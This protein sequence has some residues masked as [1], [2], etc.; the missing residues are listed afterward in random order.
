MPYGGGGAAANPSQFPSSGGGGGGSGIGPSAAGLGL[1]LMTA[2]PGAIVNQINLNAQSL[3]VSLGTCA[4][5]GTATKLGA[6][7]VVAG[8]T[9]GAGVNRLALYSEAGTLLAQTGDMTTPFASTGWAE[10]TIPATALVAG[11]NYYLG[12]VPN[13]T[14]TPVAVGYTGIDNIPVL[15]GHYLNLFENGQAT[16]PASFTPSGL[17]LLFSTLILY[18]R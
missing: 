5:A 4:V 18:A 3:A 12:V 16:V 13:Y 9:T 2:P 7:I 10:G 8:V 14:G 17:S 11:T 6:W 15:N 1:L